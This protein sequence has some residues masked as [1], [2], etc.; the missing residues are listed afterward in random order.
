MPEMRIII[1]GHSTGIHKYFSGMERDELLLFPRER[2]KKF[3]HTVTVSS[4][5]E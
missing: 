1:N 5:A 3:N 4:M 2:I